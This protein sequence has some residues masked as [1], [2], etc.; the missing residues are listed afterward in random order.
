[1]EQLYGTF[2]H[3]TFPLWRQDD[4]QADT[5]QGVGVAGHIALLPLRHPQQQRHS[6][7]IG[8]VEG[9]PLADLK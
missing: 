9:E 5:D 7:G 8:V 4:Q 3:N 6:L 2:Q 1:M